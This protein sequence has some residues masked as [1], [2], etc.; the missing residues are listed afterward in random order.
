M[1]TLRFTLDK[2]ARTSAAKLTEISGQEKLGC[3]S[4]DFLR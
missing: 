4:S 1:G 3:F 2:A